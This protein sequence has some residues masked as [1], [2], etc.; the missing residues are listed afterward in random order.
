MRLW[1]WEENHD[2][3]NRKRKVLWTVAVICWAAAL[4]LTY[5]VEHSLYGEIVETNTFIFLGASIGISIGLGLRIIEGKEEKPLTK[6]GK[7]ITGIIVAVCLAVIVWDAVFRGM[8]VYMIQLLFVLLP[9]YWSDYEKKKDIDKISMYACTLFLAAVLL[10]AG[11][12]AGA[13]LTGN[14]TT[15]QAEKT[16]AAEGFTDVEFLGWMYGSWV[17]EDAVDKSFY[18]ESMARE[19]YYMLFGRKD[20]APW[21]FV[22]DPKGGEILVAATEQTEPKLGN[23]YRSRETGE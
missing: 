14:Q 21:R 5:W 19:K 15:G 7:W 17:Y 8:I 3:Q 6:R 16:I 18:Q 9:L 20:G 13:R 10:A 2:K 11:T 22:V 12:L 23:W 1:A 4:Y